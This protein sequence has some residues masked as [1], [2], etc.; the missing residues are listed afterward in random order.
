MEKII[1]VRCI[2]HSGKYSRT[3][4]TLKLAEYSL[5]IYAKLLQRVNPSGDN[6]YHK[7]EFDHLASGTDSKI[8]YEEVDV[9]AGSGE[10]IKGYI[11]GLKMADKY[12]DTYITVKWLDTEND[13]LVAG[14]DIIEAKYD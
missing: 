8:S 2:E 14:P 1:I 6:S 12:L 4:I 10:Y 3:T 5:A 13:P 7:A 9:V 11:N